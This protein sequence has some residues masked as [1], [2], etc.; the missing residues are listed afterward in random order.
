MKHFNRL[1]RVMEADTIS[2]NGRNPK[3]QMS[4][5]NKIKGILLILFAVYLLPCDCIAQKK[6]KVWILKEDIPKEQ[7]GLQSEINSGELFLACHEFLIDEF[8][9]YDGVLKYQ[10]KETG[11]ILLNWKIKV[12]TVGG[13]MFKS[14]IWL[15]CSSRIKITDDL[16]S[17]EHRVIDIKVVKY[18]SKNGNWVYQ[19]TD[20]QNDLDEKDLE[21][22]KKVTEKVCADLEKFLN[23]Y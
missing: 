12:Q 18:A 4:R 9:S 1:N 17:L 22:F 3:S 8:V 10:D 16:I 6:K 2:K 21:N 5:G 13:F 19:G 7:C 20:D 11:S 14:D 15:N 23:R